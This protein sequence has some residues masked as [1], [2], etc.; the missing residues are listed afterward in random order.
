MR[1]PSARLGNI[2]D[3]GVA[4]TNTVTLPFRKT[5]QTNVLWKMAQHLQTM[6]KRRRAFKETPLKCPPTSFYHFTRFLKSKWL[7]L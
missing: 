1:Y 2:L 3:L 4:H 7:V 5:K 6:G